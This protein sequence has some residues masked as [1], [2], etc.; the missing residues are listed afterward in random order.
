MTMTAPS[1]PVSPMVSPSSSTERMH[2]DAGSMA[3]MTPTLLAGTYSWQIDWSRNAAELQKSCQRLL[4]ECRKVIVGQDE[5]L[6]QLILA[7]LARGHGLLVGVPRSELPAA[8]ENAYYW[9]DLIGLAVVNTRDQALGE[10]LGLIETPGNTVLRVGD[11]D[12]NE[13]LL[14]FVA[15]VVLEVDLPGRCVRVDWEAD[16]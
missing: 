12:G 2:P 10:V 4:A 16:W 15:T 13:R 6:E 14:P 9:A 11:A 3:R 8:G 1:Q 7:I 5:V